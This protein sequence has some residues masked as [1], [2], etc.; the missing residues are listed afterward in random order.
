MT[1]A[2]SPQTAADASALPLAASGMASRALAGCEARRFFASGAHTTRH[3]TEQ[4]TGMLHALWIVNAT[5]S[6]PRST[7]SKLAHAAML[8]RARSADAGT[9]DAGTIEIAGAKARVHP[10]HR[11]ELT[12]R[13]TD[14]RSTAGGRDRGADRRGDRAPLRCQAAGAVDVHRIGQR[15]CAAVSKIWA[16]WC[17]IARCQVRSTCF[18]MARSPAAGRSSPAA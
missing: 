13:M 3:A 18:A 1:H 15:G 2:S 17:M 8:R 11:T 10:A 6:S 7:W 4:S 14:L 12:V 5:R 16:G 9:T